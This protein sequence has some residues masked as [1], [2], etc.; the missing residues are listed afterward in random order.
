[1]GVGH[2]A[3][4]TPAKPDLPSAAVNGLR[5]AL[6][7]TL[8]LTVLHH[9][10]WLRGWDHLFMQRVLS[11]W[12]LS[13]AEDSPRSAA[14]A[15]IEAVILDAPLRVLA[16][17]D[18]S[19]SPDMIRR[20]GGVRP[21]SRAA[22]AEVLAALDAGLADQA[23]QAGRPQRPLLAIDIDL[24]PLEGAAE[25]PALTHQLLTLGRWAD[26]A[27]IVM[28]RQD[29]AAAAGRDAY[30]ERL[31]KRLPQGQLHLVS[32]RV[33]LGRGGIPMD[34]LA[35]YPSLGWAMGQR[36]LGRALPGCAQARQLGR[37]ED[38]AWR[39]PWGGADSAG[40][41]QFYN[42]TL[43]HSEQ[44]RHVPI[45]ASGEPGQP[46]AQTVARGLRDS[47][48]PLRAPV[49]LLAV[50]S[51]RGLDHY[52]TPGAMV[53]PIA[54]PSLHAL[55]ALSMRH[56]LSE[57]SLRAPLVDLLLGALMVAGGLSLRALLL[58]S[59]RLAQA[60][61]LRLALQAAGLVVLLW[62]L[63][64]LALWLAVGALDAH[65][66]LNPL[67]VL[68]GLLLHS[69]LDAWEEQLH[70]QTP[71]EQH[72]PRLPWRRPTAVLSA[73]LSPWC[74]PRGRGAD[75]WLAWLICWGLLLAPLVQAGLHH[76]SP[77]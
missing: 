75:A 6:L 15:L 58:R 13:Q 26:L 44:L 33:W 60:P 46:L 62:L 72:P 31:C 14:P 50:E 36:L 19:P 43:L 23:D 47:P 59:P 68:L 35:D 22:M 27:L 10:H 21:V 45:S 42:W 8:A 48:E 39:N 24:A 11:H 1:M 37:S 51:A 34:Y 76:W 18:A 74:W 32:P 57:S 16:L 77:A 28:P 53:E 40:A 69:L 56:P 66:W 29:A 20:V 30:F 5:M 41:P 65:V 61:M 12:V 67:Y 7:L 63:T 73:F 4:G 55:Q 25:D 3:A 70:A 64:L 38:Q 2:S 54:G 49:L 17:E 9:S 52:P 71:P